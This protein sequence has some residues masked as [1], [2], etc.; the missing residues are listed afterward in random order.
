M[1]ESFFTDED[2]VAGRHLPDQAPELSTGMEALA[3]QNEAGRDA[4]LVPPIL[5]QCPDELTIKWINYL[6]PDATT[7]QISYANSD[8]F[9]L[10][11]KRRQGL[12][13]LCGA[14][15]ALQSI[16]MPLLYRTVV[17]SDP[18]KLCLL[19]RTL[20]D[21]PNYGYEVKS[22]SVYRDFDQ[23]D[24]ESQNELDRGGDPGTITLSEFSEALVAVLMR[25]PELR[26][27]TLSLNKLPN[28]QDDEAFSRLGNCLVEDMNR[29]QT[30]LP[31]VET[32]A[33]LLTPGARSEIQ[34]DREYTVFKGLL[35]FSALRN[36]I[37]RRPPIFTP[38]IDVWSELLRK[39]FPPNVAILFRFG[40][41]C[42]T[43]LHYV[44][45]S[46]N[47]TDM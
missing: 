16:A 5:Q 35:N 24:V 3:I 14:T 47:A 4:V 21:S 12:Q 19:R 34:R 8:E 42:Y 40:K 27:L 46:C 22:L 9:R 2:D 18:H 33:I 32:L 7:A 20:E 26:I 37:V 29:N 30:L 44:T 1:A 31:G 45:L 23:S 6:S 38:G 10:V 15:R 11:E 39:L 28:F 13:G 17:V 41:T 36:I 25:T 43:M